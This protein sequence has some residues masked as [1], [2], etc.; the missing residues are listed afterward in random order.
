M[1][2]AGKLFDAPCIRLGKSIISKSPVFSQ[3]LAVCRPSREIFNQRL[4]ARSDIAPSTDS[5]S[6]VGVEEGLAD[7]GVLPRRPGE[8]AKQVVVSET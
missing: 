1:S 8:L 2:V 6:P 7:L 5:D 4:S 3:Q